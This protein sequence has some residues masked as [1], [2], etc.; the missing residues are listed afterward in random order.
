MLPSNAAGGHDKPV[1]LGSN[2]SIASHL[3]R[4]HSRWFRLCFFSVLGFLALH[5]LYAT[6][7]PFLPF[8]TQTWGL[9]LFV[10]FIVFMM[11]SLF[12][13]IVHVPFAGAIAVLSLVWSRFRGWCFYSFV[14]RSGRTKWATRPWLYSLVWYVLLVHHLAFD[15]DP[16][17]TLVCASALLLV[18]PE[19]WQLLGR[20]WRPLSLQLR[21]VVWTVLA[22]LWL[23]FSR[24]LADIVGIV[25][26]SIP[27]FLLLRQGGRVLSLRDRFALLMAFVPVTQLA[28]AL[29]PLAL[30][31]H[32]GKWL[33]SGMAYS[34]CE[35]P[36][37]GSLF[38]AVPRCNNPM[39]C[40][41]YG[42]VDEYDLRDFSRR[43]QHR[44]FSDRYAGRL[45]RIVCMDDVVQVGMDFTVFEGRRYRQN[46]LEFSID[47][48]KQF[49]PSVV[50]A[51]GDGIAYDRKRGAVFYRSDEPD[52]HIIRRDLAT[53]A[54][55]RGP[56]EPSRRPLTTSP[57][58][59]GLGARIRHALALDGYIDIGIHEGRDSLFLMSYFGNIVEVDLATLETKN[60]YPYAHGWEFTIDE[61]LDRLYVTGSF[62]LEVISLRTSEVVGRARIGFGSR[63]PAF[64]ARNDLLYVPSMGSGRIHV[65]D[66]R[67]LKLLGTLPVGL[68]PRHPYVSKDN[69]YLF[70]SSA[71]AHY[72]WSTDALT[73]Q[74][75]DEPP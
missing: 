7:L 11:L 55:T 3:P 15:V 69:R 62:G 58:S 34:F 70:A 75:R 53:G 29:F 66:R 50:G 22:G 9:A 44:F 42:T 31:L 38:A 23:L 10:E 72:Y 52:V 39:D 48:P 61:E 56:G 65:F 74:F 67:T 28:T 60:V 63:R 51:A 17:L 14:D 54:I 2:L 21:G 41:T 12:G 45:E 71:S 25:V 68:G 19:S 26:W 35:V 20:L 59:L 40:L 18:L 57:T 36:R 37:T 43:A 6:S 64:D 73:S 8:V 46:L 33:G 16:Y 13:A 32:G 1:M 24:D 27:L 30:P 5:T 49:T 47:D 4:W